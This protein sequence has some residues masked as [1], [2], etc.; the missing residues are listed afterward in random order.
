MSLHRAIS[1]HR[2]S[3]RAIRI[4]LTCGLAFIFLFPPTKQRNNGSCPEIPGSQ[5]WS[6][7]DF[8]SIY[9]KSFNSRSRHCVDL[10]LQYEVLIVREKSLSEERRFRILNILFAKRN[11]PGNATWLIR[12]RWQFSKLRFLSNGTPIST[13]RTDSSGTSNKGKGRSARRPPGA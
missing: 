12:K 7:I 13:V 11:F 2:S 4:S 9:H 1:D 5:F 8:P 3:L 6:G 10:R